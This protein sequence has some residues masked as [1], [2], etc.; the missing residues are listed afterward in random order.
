MANM[1]PGHFIEDIVD[2]E[3]SSGQVKEV[4]TRFPPDPNG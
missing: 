2:E 3:L 1:D 4:I